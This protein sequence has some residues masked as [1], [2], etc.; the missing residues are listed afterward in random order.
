M[1]SGTA[2]T[3]PLVLLRTWLLPL[4][5]GAAAFGLHYALHVPAGPLPPPSPAEVEAD[6]KAADKKK[7]DEEKAQREADRKA[8]KTKPRAERSGARE[9]AYEPF[10][11]PRP[12]HI[13]EQLWAYYEPMAFKKEPTFEAWQTAHKSLLTQIVD[14]TRRT[15]LPDGPELT[16]A[17]SEC[18]T[19]RCRFTITATTQEPLDAII[20]VLRQ[21]RL[22]T[23]PLWHSFEADTPA[24]DKDKA[25]NATKPPRF[26]AELTVSFTRDLPTLADMSLPEL[27]PLR[28]QSPAT[29]GPIPA[30]HIPPATGAPGT[31]AAPAKSTRGTPKSTRT[32]PAPTPG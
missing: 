5:V 13:I 11:R 20:P 15:A 4:T 24:A 3:A 6:K 1:T 22:G 18:H 10:R 17:T 28:T 12:D 27:G 23:G 21:L 26:K 8:G 32:P 30:S 19:I 29:P 7:K 9:L 16:V 31:G 2:R 25:G 14:A